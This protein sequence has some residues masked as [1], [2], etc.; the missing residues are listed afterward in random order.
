M[1]AARSQRA[2]PPCWS[3]WRTSR[4]GASSLYYFFVFGGFVA[5]AL[6]LPRY[7]VG[8]YGLDIHRRHAGRGLF[9]RRLAFRILGGALSDRFGARAVMYWTF[10]GS[11]VCT[12][13]L[14][15]PATQYV[16]QGIRGPIDSAS[17][18]ASCPSCC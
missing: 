3:R 16:V 9:H 5:L 13:L 10:R 6:W 8:V 18:S 1:P 14:S 7:F 4:S 15:Y 2:S 12:F 11:L 17:P